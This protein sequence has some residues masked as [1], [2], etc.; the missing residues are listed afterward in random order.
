M[1]ERE[2]KD[3]QQLY[4][5][6]CGAEARPGN[7]FCTSCGE[8]VEPEYGAGGH[9]AAGS[10][11]EHPYGGPRSVPLASVNAG[12]SG[13]GPSDGYREVIERVR[14]AVAELHPLLQIAVLLVGVATFGTVVGLVVLILYL[15]WA[16]LLALGIVASV[17][18]VVWKVIES[19]QGLAQGQ[20][21][22][23]VHQDLLGSRGGGTP[24]ASEARL[25]DPSRRV[26]ARN[27]DRHPVGSHLESGSGT[28]SEGSIVPRHPH[29]P[30]G[31]AEGY[32]S[33]SDLDDMF[34][35]YVAGAPREIGST[36]ET[37]AVVIEKNGYWHSS[38][39]IVKDV[40]RHVVGLL[41]ILAKADRRVSA[42]E[43]EV[44]SG[45]VGGAMNHRDLEMIVDA[46]AAKTSVDEFLSTTPEYVRAAV[47]HDKEKGTNIAAIVLVCV[48][49]IGRK[50]IAADSHISEKEVALLARHLVHL[51]AFI[52]TR[53]VSADYH[54]GAT[55]AG[56][57]AVPPKQKEGQATLSVD[58]ELAKLHRLVGLPGV[59]REV[60]TLTNLI[61]VRQERAEKGLPAPP[62]SF[63][64]VFTGNP[65]T[66]KTTVARLLADIY[67]SLGILY[68]GHQIGR[69][70]V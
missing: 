5:P 7:T 64:L 36:L 66:G 26:Q 62:M 30:D 61:R 31:R 45:L 48:A 21:G 51:R 49:G 19:G 10:Q 28:T 69:A 29:P 17:V 67:R 25:S 14:R 27:T 63:H 55:E 11:Q 22:D 4:C 54:T 42:S 52:E 8:R 16:V 37:A 43:L 68:K 23:P 13:T 65:G 53:G 40:T 50:M 44:L 12:G 47:A 38:T 3:Q 34:G 33:E 46:E 9:E 39:G 2:G 70:H 24:A 6:S 15:Y 18:W 56:K 41:S 60:E 1:S 35:D 20:G 57:E 32:A 59:K 58:E